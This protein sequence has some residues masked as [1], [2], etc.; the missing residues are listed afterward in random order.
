MFGNTWKIINVPG[1]QVLSNVQEFRKRAGEVGCSTNG[2]LV[3]K[4]L[5]MRKQAVDKVMMFTDCQLWNSNSNTDNIVQL[6]RQYKSIVPNARLYLFDLAGLG[7]SPLEILKDD[8]YLIAGWSDKIFNVLESL[9]NGS[10]AMEMINQIK[11]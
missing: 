9:E 1:K 8:V 5:L 11:L 7:K 10:T 3:I 4:D 2:Y 6:W